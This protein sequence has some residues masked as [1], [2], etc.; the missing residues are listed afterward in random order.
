MTTSKCQ[1][2]KSPYHKN[3]FCICRD[4]STFDPLFMENVNDIANT[5]AEVCACTVCS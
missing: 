2:P 3:D 5:L 1:P 4:P